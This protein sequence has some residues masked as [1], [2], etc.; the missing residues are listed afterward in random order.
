[1]Q[2]AEGRTWRP[3]LDEQKDEP[4]DEGWRIG[5]LQ[6]RVNALEAR[7]GVLRGRLC[8]ARDRMAKLERQ[9]R[10]LQEELMRPGRGR[11]TSHTTEGDG[12]VHSRPCRLTC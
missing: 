8:D 12:P 3:R 4:A 1:M 5:G 7:N 9:N 6:E 2:V 11:M 10:S